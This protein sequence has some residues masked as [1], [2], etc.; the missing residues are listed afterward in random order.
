MVSQ[1]LSQARKD[2]AT[3]QVQ[4]AAV[5]AP[6]GGHLLRISAADGL[7][8]SADSCCTTG[9]KVVHTVQHEGEFI[10]TFPKAYHSGFSLGWNAAEAANFAVMDWLPFGF[11]AMESYSK[12]CSKS[13]TSKS[14]NACSEAQ[15]MVL[16]PLW[17]DRHVME[18]VLIAHV[19]I[20]H[21]LARFMQAC[22]L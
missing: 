7:V 6:C 14:G 8:K 4:L 12:V 13:G 9:V 1:L 10:V 18:W 20:R 3:P 5:N 2:A 16:V 19:L 17:E 11:E 21:G 22:K 15:H